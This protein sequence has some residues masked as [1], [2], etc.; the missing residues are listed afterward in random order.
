M[1]FLEQVHGQANVISKLTNFYNRKQIP[2]ALLFTG[3]KGSGQHFISRQF[4]KKLIL[5]DSPNDR[6][7]RKIDKLEYPYVKYIIPLPRG[8]NELPND[9]PVQ[10]LSQSEIELLNSE[11]NKKSENP[12]YQIK[13]DNA[14]NIKINSIREIKKNLSINYEDIKHRLI[15]IEDAHLMSHEA[16]NALLKNLE[17]PPE[18]ILFILITEFPESLLPTIKSRCWQI[19][20]QPL[21]NEIISN[22]LNTYFDIDLEISQQVSRFSNGSVPIALDLLD[23]GFE[24]LL[25]TTINI[26]R[27]SLARR[28]NTA[29]T[30]FKTSLDDYSINTTKIIIDLILTWFNDIIKNRYGNENYYFE[31]HKDTLVKFN[32]KF[33]KTEISDLVF[34]LEDL[35]LNLDKNVNLNLIMLNII[36]NIASIGI[37]KI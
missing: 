14:N 22:I 27:F 18:R 21:N 26:L 37:R 33:K 35:K 6:I 8:K 5:V 31:K 19:N 13:I 10:K 2:H 29:I 30:L 28:Y 24:Q 15:L 25:D 16:Q 12:Y 17:E 9:S 3:P 20:F 23:N 1:D 7:E 32:S 34:K 11:I 36:F 4:I